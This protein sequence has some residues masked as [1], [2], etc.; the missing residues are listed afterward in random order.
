VAGTVEFASPE[1]MAAVSEVLA[2]AVRGLDTGG[3]SY[4]VSEEFTDP[5]THLLA[6]GATSIGWHFRVTDGVSEAFDGPLSGADLE[7]TV[8]YDT[9]LP[10]ARLVYDSP[11]ALEEL[12]KTRAEATAAGKLTRK[13]DESLLPPE[14]MQ[15]LFDVHN[16]MAR[17]T[18]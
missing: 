7:T 2:D 15:R 9:V 3:K 11:E 5:P 12:Q 13:G 18:K 4:T 16:D 10:L 17:R 1:W 6:D 8:D 14:L